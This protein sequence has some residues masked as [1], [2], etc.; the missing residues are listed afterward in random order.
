ML[1]FF[2]QWTTFCQKSS[3][4]PVYLGR[5]CT[6]GLIVWVAQAP[7]PLQ[8]CDPSRGLLL[9]VKL[10][11]FGHLMQTANSWKKILMLGKIE[12][13]RRRGW[14]RT[15]WVDSITDSM[16]TNLSKLQEMVEDRGAW[17]APVHGVTKGQTWLSDWTTT[18]MFWP[19]W[20]VLELSWHLWVCHLACWC[21]TT[22]VSWGS[23]S[24]GSQPFC[25]L[26]LIW[27]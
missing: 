15:R 8:G 18:I 10:Q 13:K 17:H 3:L 23:S 22:S 12:G 2:F 9:K 14:Q 25:H 19:L 21:L 4:W 26:G 24:R 11:D 27:F 7:L 20:S 16:D 6:A 1:H 5:S